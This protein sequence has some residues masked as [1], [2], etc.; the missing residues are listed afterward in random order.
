M[1]HVLQGPVIKVF[2]GEKNGWLHG[3]GISFDSYNKNQQD[4]QFFK[5]IW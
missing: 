2:E 4:A 1:V 3:A 5:F